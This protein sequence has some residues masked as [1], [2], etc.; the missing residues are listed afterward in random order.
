MSRLVPH[1]N[2]INLLT[3]HPGLP[4][5]LLHCLGTN[6]LAAAVSELHNALV[7]KMGK[8]MMPGKESVGKRTQEDEEELTKR[9][10]S[11]WEQVM[12]QGLCNNDGYVVL[13]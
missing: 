1:C 6:Y 11:I 5:E 8:E 3:L 2:A 12:L 10:G 13:L 4:R 9:W 7:R